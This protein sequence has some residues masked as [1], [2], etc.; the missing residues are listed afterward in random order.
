MRRSLAKKSCMIEKDPSRRQTMHGIPQFEKLFRKTF[1]NAIKIFQI[2][3]GIKKLE[4]ERSVKGTL[5]RVNTGPKRLFIKLYFVTQQFSHQTN[6]A[7][8]AIAYT[9]VHSN[10]R[11]VRKIMLIRYRA[12]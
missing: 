5:E 8:S 7:D 12:R 11:N 10:M 3:F 4:T 1:T 9:R 2:F 6:D